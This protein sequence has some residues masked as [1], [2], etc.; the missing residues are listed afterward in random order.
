MMIQRLT[1]ASLLALTLLATAAPAVA[2]VQPD[3]S[4]R[5]E[6]GQILSEYRVN[7]K[8]YAIKVEPKGGSTYFLVD[9]NG[10]GNFQRQTSDSVDVPG[11]V[12]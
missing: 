8:L 10:D 1:S 9:R 12:Q 4:V 7:G 2:Q 6:A 5:Q 3:V 11:W